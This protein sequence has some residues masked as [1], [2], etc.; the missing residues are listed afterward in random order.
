MRWV[1]LAVACVWTAGCGSSGAQL[2]VEGTV[3][4]AGQP[5]GMGTIAFIA[6]DGPGPNAGE[7][8]RDGRFTIP[9]AQGPQPGVYRVEVRWAKPTGKTFKHPETGELMD[10]FEE[11]LP[12]KYHDK[13]VLT[14]EFKAGGGPI[15]LDLAP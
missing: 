11:G 13:S 7:A 1:L 15:E 9:A 12:E 6:P 3:R 5:I 10:T 2:P 4:Y 14:H 8:I